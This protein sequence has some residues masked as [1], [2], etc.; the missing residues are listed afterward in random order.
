MIETMARRIEMIMVQVMSF[1][2]M[3]LV[4]ERTLLL[5][6]ERVWL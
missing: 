4:N 6:A 2:F 5:K 1:P 3:K